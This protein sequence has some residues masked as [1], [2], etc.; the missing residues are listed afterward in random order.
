VL[1][2]ITREIFDHLVDLAALEMDEGEAEYLR[3]ELNSQLE[4]IHE[5]EAIELHPG[6]AI[7]SHGVPYTDDISSPLRE[8]TIEPCT[9]ADA[10]LEQAPEVEDRYIRVPDIPS[11]ALE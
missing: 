8:D 2:E 5:L 10:I 6:V 9:E 7:T 4:A 1:E 3:S 11:E